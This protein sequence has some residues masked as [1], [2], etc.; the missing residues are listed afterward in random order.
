MYSPRKKK[1]KAQKALAIQSLLS[2]STVRLFLFF[3]FFFFWEKTEGKINKFLQLNKHT[4]RYSS[5]QRADNP[6]LKGTN[7]LCN[8][9]MSRKSGMSQDLCSTGFS[10]THGA[11]SLL[12]GWGSSS[13]ST[14]G[15]WGGRWRRCGW[16]KTEL[17]HSSLGIQSIRSRKQNKEGVIYNTKSCPFSPKAVEF[18]CL[19]APCQPLEVSFS[20]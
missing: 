7:K 19:L 14:C 20:A 2:F 15:R 18:L 11:F 9:A 3:S 8:T 13:N 4:E 17:G 6:Y 10:I 16:K 12:W 5:R 1:K